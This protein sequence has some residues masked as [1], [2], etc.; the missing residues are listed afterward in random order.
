MKIFEKLFEIFL[1][2]A[3]FIKIDAIVGGY[4]AEKHRHALIIRISSLYGA[5]LDLTFSDKVDYYYSL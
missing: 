3:Q 2:F 4:E 1:I 5:I